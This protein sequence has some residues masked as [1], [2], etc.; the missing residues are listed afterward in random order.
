MVWFEEGGKKIS[1]LLGIRRPLS[2]LIPSLLKLDWNESTGEIRQ[3]SS[4]GE[5]HCT[6]QF[7]AIFVTPSNRF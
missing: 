3:L 1:N 7:Q 5:C 2:N 4:V 6:Q